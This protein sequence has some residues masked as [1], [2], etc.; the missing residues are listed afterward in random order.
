MDPRPSAPEPAAAPAPSRGWGLAI[1]AAAAAAL[2]VWAL[3]LDF[4]SD[5]AF[6]SFRYARN[7]ATGRGLVFNPGERVEGYTNF[8]EVLVLAGAHRLG[9]DLVLAGRAFSLAGG[10]AAVALAHRAAVRLTGRQL[11]GAVAAALVALDPYVAAWAGAALESTAFAALLLGMV[12]ALSD[13]TPT[14]GRFLA[15]SLLGLLLGMTRPEGVALYAVA[16]GAAVLAVPGGW[17]ERGRTLWPGLALFAGAGA[18]YFAARWAYFGDPLPN[19][20]HAKSGFTARHVERGLA[21]LALFVRNPF[22]GV[23]L[24][25]VVAGAIAA[26]ARR[27]VAL[28]AVPAAALVLVVLE[29]GDGLPMYRFLVPVVPLA[30][31]LAALGCDGLAR[32]GARLLPRGGARAGLAVGV[33]TAGVA[34]GLSLSPAEDPQY[35]GFVAQRDLE[36][37][38]WTAAGRALARSYPPGTSFAAVPIGAL[39]YYS[40]LPCLDLVGLTDRTI[41]R[42]PLPQVGSGWAGHEKHNGPYV[43]AR[44]PDLMLLGNVYV[45][46]H[47]ELPRN[48]FPKFQLPEV[49]LREGDIFTD[50]AFAAEYEQRDLQVGPRQWLHLFARRGGVAAR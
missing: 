48:W 24:P 21:Y 18:L 39:A 40:D 33:V 5:D 19:T 22:V 44:R 3:R 6:I 12:L 35:L 29:G 17:R 1:V 16:A 49:Q 43:L 34:A 14:R 41:A 32:A 10:I 8:L 37:P 31:A 7:W 23:A 42:T 45:D 25:L 50:P 46:D 9:A 47:P 28:V 15:A 11:L 26:A 13:G 27:R 20:F 36:L 30:A 4:L 38:A 2:T